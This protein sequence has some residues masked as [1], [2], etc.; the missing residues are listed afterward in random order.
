MAR[1]DDYINAKKIAVQDL[2]ND[3]LSDI[4]NRSGY[5]LVDNNRLRVPFLNRLY[6]VSWPDF[7][8]KDESPEPKEVPIQEQVIILHYLLAKA[9]ITGYSNWI[10]FREIPGA[11]FYYSAFVNRAI[12]P[13]KDIFGN[14]ISLFA[15][16][17]KCLEG[18]AFDAGDAAF[19]F[20]LF[21]HV[22]LQLIIW[23]GDE[24][25]PSEA[26]ILFNDNIGDILSPEDVAWLS[27]ALVY[28]LVA[29]SR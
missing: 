21:P 17:A 26:N 22:S 10:S 4:A 15:N 28:R 23:Y 20:I 7:E 13:L 29:L 9:I 12:N 19:E 5:E 25:F 8:F 24:E 2:S 27:G 6:I 14:N 1:V 11:S 16:A 18:K 3:T